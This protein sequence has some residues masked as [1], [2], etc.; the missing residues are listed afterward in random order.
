[1]DATRTYSF[2]LNKADQIFDILLEAKQIKL[3]GRHKILTHEELRAK[4]Y[5]K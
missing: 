2:D 3:I 5:C 4:D 1:M